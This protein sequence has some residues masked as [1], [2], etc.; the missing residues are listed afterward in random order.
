MINEKFKVIIIVQFIASMLVVCS[1]LYQLAKT[2]LSAKYIPLMLYTICMCIQILIYCWYGN[3]VKL[4]VLI[5]IYNH[6]Y[7]YFE[8]ILSVFK[9]IFKKCESKIRNFITRSLPTTRY[10][11]GV[12]F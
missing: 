6:I 11:M 12:F 5:N 10:R 7:T 9:N 2:S 1:S 4:K 8:C 3:E